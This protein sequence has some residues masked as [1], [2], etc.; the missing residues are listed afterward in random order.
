MLL[1]C[2]GALL[3]AP[4]RTVMDLYFNEDLSLQE[5]ADDQG[6][7]RQAV[8]DMVSRTLRKLEGYERRMGLVEQ[9]SRRLD[10]LNECLRLAGACV[11]DEVRTP[12]TARLT[13]L[14]QEEEQPSWRLKA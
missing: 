9:N 13:S 12:L 2:Y 10:A 14:I 3:T 11:D 1:S 8:H 6:I 7:S 4:Q 5:I